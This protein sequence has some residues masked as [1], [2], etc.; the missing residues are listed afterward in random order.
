MKLVTGVILKINLKVDIKTDKDYESPQQKRTNHPQRNMGV[1][2]SLASYPLKWV[3]PFSLL[4]L[5]QASYH[6]CPV[7]I[8]IT[9]TYIINISVKGYNFTKGGIDPP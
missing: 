4:C 2:L 8:K 7:K 9:F 3:Y 6:P 5:L 1:S